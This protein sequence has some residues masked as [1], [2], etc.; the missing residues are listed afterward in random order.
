M[1]ANNY[2]APHTIV[3]MHQHDV[4][5]IAHVKHAVGDAVGESEKGENREKR[6][7]RERQRER[8]RERV[9]VCEVCVCVCEQQCRNHTNAHACVN[10]TLMPNMLWGMLWERVRRERRRG[11]RGKRRSM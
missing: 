2:N 8:E 11:G 7:R 6:E 4:H 9:C 5:A 3:H 10:T 1:C